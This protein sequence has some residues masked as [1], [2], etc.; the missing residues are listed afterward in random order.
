M[1]IS[2]YD[3]EEGRYFIAFTDTCDVVVHKNRVTCLSG[4]VGATF[5]KWGDY[6][7]EALSFRSLGAYANVRVSPREMEEI[8]RCRKWLREED[9][10]REPHA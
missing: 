10:A 9:G 3:T 1:R 5:D 6:D 8:E 2:R 4:G 7:G